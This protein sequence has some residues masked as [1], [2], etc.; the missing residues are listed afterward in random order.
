[1]GQ[2]MRFEILRTLLWL[3]TIVGVNSAYA[4]DDFRDLPIIV[5]TINQTLE[6][7]RTGVE[8]SCRGGMV[9]A[10]F[11]F[12]EFKRLTSERDRL[13]VTTGVLEGIALAVG[14]HELVGLGMKTRGP[15]PQHD[16]DQ[17]ERAAV[18]HT[19]GFPGGF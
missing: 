13:F 19:F 2:V 10:E 16:Q 7:Q 6:T 15:Q 1:M 18:T 9:E 11:A 8:H 3:L 5:Q 17:R 4:S 14:R 12:A